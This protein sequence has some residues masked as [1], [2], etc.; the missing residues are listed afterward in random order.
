MNSS[1]Y[2]S[3]TVGGKKYRYRF[4]GVTSVEHSLT[5]NLKSASA[6]G[7]DVVNG[8]RNKPDRVTLSV[9]ETDA[10]H[11]PGWAADMLEA[12]DAL[13]RNRVLC[14]VVTSMGTYRRMLL[15][16]ISAKQDGNCQDGWSGTLAFTEYVSG[17]GKTGSGAKAKN[18][19]STRKNTGST[20]SKKVTGSAFQ[21]LLERAGVNSMNNEE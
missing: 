3:C 18:N 21:Q 16:E 14:K 13:K 4:T 19:S 1:A 12:M 8:A 9:I 15:T 6:Q 10:E 11:M 2:V 20:G 17:K 5:L 7:K